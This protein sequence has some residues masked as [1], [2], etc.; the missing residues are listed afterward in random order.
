MTQTEYFLGWNVEIQKSS[1][2]IY[3]QLEKLTNQISIRNLL[4][5]DYVEDVLDL[6]FE[7]KSS[8]CVVGAY[9]RGCIAL[10]RA[11]AQLSGNGQ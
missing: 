11:G 3:T 10:P 2:L 5:M 1:A 7:E 8:P 9:I 6:I 4:L